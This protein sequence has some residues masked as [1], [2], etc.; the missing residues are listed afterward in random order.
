VVWFGP[1]PGTVTEPDE[2]AAAEH[3]PLSPTSGNRQ[4]VGGPV[5]RAWRE[6]TLTRAKEL[7]SLADWA[8]QYPSAHRADQLREAIDCHLAAAREA[9]LTRRRTADQLP[10]SA[11]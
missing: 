3:V 6:G 5:S 8:A 2:T 4:P 9:A 11:P 1:G 7:E 10:S